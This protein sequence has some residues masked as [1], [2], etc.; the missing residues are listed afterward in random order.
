MGQSEALL[1][2]YYAATIQ[3]AS[4]MLLA[5][6]SATFHPFV[7][8]RDLPVVSL[9]QQYDGKSNQDAGEKAKCEFF[10]NGEDCVSLLKISVNSPRDSLVVCKRCRSDISSK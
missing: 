7:L 2:T 5:F 9:V 1:Q 6:V 10:R 8:V 3:N 4:G